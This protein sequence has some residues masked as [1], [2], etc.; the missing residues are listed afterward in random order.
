MSSLVLVK[1]DAIKL[2]LLGW[3]IS[4]FEHQDI[5][6]IGLVRMDEELCRKHYADHVAKE[7]YPCLQEFMCSAPVCAIAVNGPVSAIRSIAMGI[8]RQHAQHVSGP[9]NLVHS[10][11]SIIAAE[12]EL[13]IWFPYRPMRWNPFNKVVQD[14]RDGTI[15][16]EVTNAVREAKGLTIPWTPEIAEIEVHKKPVF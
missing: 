7:F 4:C 2:K 12:R 14:H 16:V 11:D 15:D 8:R 1:P 3:C 13:D 5:G 10:S 6:D 9:R